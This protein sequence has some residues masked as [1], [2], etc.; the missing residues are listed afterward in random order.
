MGKGRGAELLS[1]LW[2]GCKVPSSSFWGSVRFPQQNDGWGQ[3]LTFL[4]CF[5]LRSATPAVH[6]KGTVVFVTAD[7][8]ALHR[9][10]Q[11]SF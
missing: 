8:K 10:I 4:L 2:G 11:I 9:D 7:I 6:E 3:K 1:E 5:V